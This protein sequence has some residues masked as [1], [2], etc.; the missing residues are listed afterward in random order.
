M[1]TRHSKT[2]KDLAAKIQSGELTRAE[3]AAQAG[4]NPGTLGVWLSR[5]NVTAPKNPDGT[6]KLY[7]TAAQK[8]ITDPDKVKLLDEAVAR[9]LDSNL[10]V[11]QVSEMYPTL[12]ATTIA[13]RVRKYRLEHGQ[14]VQKRRTRKEL[15]ETK[16][17]D[18]VG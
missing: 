2:F 10:S 4:I 16:I 9:V 1:I 6:R 17:P 13:A 5:S 15:A 11:T 8:K 18:L 12:S 3:A 7:G 14:H